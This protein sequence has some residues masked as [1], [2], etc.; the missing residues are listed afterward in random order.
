MHVLFCY[1]ELMMKSHDSRMNQKNFDILSWVIF[2]VSVFLPFLVWGSNLSWDFN[3]VSIY[4]FF[5]LLGLIAWMTMWTHYVTGAIRIRNPK[6]VKP[7]HYSTVTGYLVL[8]CLLL[9][10]GLLA[11]AQ[12]R[13]GQGLPPSSF[14]AYTGDGLKLAVMFGS[15]SLLIFL[16]FE[17]FNRLKD[18][19]LVKKYWWAISLS[20]S[21]AM[22][23]IFIHGLRLGNN[24]QSSLFTF[25]W[26]L[27]GL[28]LLPCFYIIHLEDFKSISD[29]SKE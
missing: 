16:S 22:T 8:A 2:A 27:Y 5:P 3:N 26:V 1:A 28:L 9:H 4:S 6:L 10:P 18:R 29:K 21:L 25:V 13:N 15:I 23:L 19:Q 12:N 17:V 20:Q 11:Y 24:L 14:F 7:N